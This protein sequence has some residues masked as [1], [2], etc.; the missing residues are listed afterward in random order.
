MCQNKVR[1]A[2]VGIDDFQKGQ[3]QD[4]ARW[5]YTTRLPEWPT[6]TTKS[7]VSSGGG[8]KP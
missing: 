7:S 2:S 5:G 1:S 8:M 6:S 3:E 4:G